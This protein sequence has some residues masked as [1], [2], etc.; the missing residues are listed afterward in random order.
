MVEDGHAER[1]ALGVGP[2]VSLKPEGVDG[3]DEGLDGV[4]RGAGNGR[5]LDTKEEI[6]QISVLVQSCLPNLDGKFSSIIRLN[7]KL[8][9]V[10]ANRKNVS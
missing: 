6:F 10:L 4:Q 9:Q 1:L 2:Q 8:G 5:V 7:F 3:R